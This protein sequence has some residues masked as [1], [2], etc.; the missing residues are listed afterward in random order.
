MC[1]CVYTSWVLC[2][3]DIKCESL[4]YS[5]TELLLH[6]CSWKSAVCPFPADTLHHWLRERELFSTVLCASSLFARLLRL[7]AR[8]NM[9][10]SCQVWRWNHCAASFDRWRR[11]W[12]RRRARSPRCPVSLTPLWPFPPLLGYVILGARVKG[13][14]MKEALWWKKALW[15]HLRCRQAACSI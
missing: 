8:I 13:C 11:P 4:D 9:L 15:K 1:A 3:C 12:E 6:V 5:R 2:D 10:P 14:V 7:D